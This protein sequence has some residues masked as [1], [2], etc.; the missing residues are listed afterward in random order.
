MGD[1]MNDFAV[2]VFDMDE[3][4]YLY[5]MALDANDESLLNRIS[6]RYTC[7]PLCTRMIPNDQYQEHFDSH[8]D[9]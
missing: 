8:P 5:L 7:C 3:L 6:A 1:F 4:Y 2:F 9:Y